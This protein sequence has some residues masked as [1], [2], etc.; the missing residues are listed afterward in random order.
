M[1][2]ITREE[3]IA[4]NENQIASFGGYHNK[5]DNVFNRNSFEYLISSVE[6]F[7]KQEHVSIFDIAAKYLFQII[8]NHI[9]CDGNKRTGFQA[10]RIFLEKN[11]FFLGDHVDDDMVIDLVL[12][13]ESGEFDH[14]DIS[15]WFMLNTY[16]K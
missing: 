3:L 2:F 7:S 13:T 5:Q 15:G 4:L 9:F 10:A 11:C 16:S 8:K 1:K 6:W 12:K 14:D